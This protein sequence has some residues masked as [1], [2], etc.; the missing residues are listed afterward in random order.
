[1]FISYHLVLIYYCFISQIPVD[2]TLGEVTVSVSGAKPKITVVDPKGEQLTGPPKLITTVDLSEIMVRVNFN[3]KTRSCFQL[4]VSNTELGPS[5]KI[6]NL[7]AI[8]FK[9]LTNLRKRYRI[10]L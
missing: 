2:S 9:I 4:L 10:T 8:L 5:D 1:M 7:K 3:T 6:S